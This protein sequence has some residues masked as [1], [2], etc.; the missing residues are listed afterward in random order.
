M[1]YFT[2]FTSNTCAAGG[3]QHFFTMQPDEI[4]TGRVF[5]RIAVGGEYRYSLLFSNVIDST[6]SNGAVSHKNLI[7]DEWE[8]CSARIGRCAGLAAGEAV[9][10]TDPGQIAV[11]GWKTLTFDGAPTKTVMPGAFFCS[12]PVSFAAQKDEYLCVELTFSGSMLPYHEESILPIYI[13]EGDGWRYDK[14]MPLPSMIGCDRPVAARIAYL[15]D[16]ITQGCGTELNAYEHW[17]A[18]LS[19]KLDEKYACWNLG[20]G[21]GRANDAA[22]DGA[23][24]FKARQNDLVVVC[25]G[26]NDIFQGMGEVQIKK[27]LTYIV[28]ALKKAGARVVLQTV[29]PFDYSG[30]YVGLWQRVNEFIKTELSQKADLIFDVVPVL[31]REEAPHLARYC[32]HP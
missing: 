28:E 19:R 3:N 26:V 2:Q 31:G 32:G 10:Q 6:F 30:D 24:L 21:Y 9:K 13:K 17:N 8:L 27:D 29:P 15:G 1:K 12:D 7:C 16:S 11:D 25:Y 14:K 5:Y 22:S 4:R 20:L 23:W 18:V